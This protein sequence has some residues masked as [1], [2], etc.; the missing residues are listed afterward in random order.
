MKRTAENWLKPCTA[1]LALAMA[2][3]ASHARALDV[4]DPTG[5]NYSSVSDSSHYP[6]GNN[7]IAVNLF[8]LDVTGVALGTIIGSTEFARDGGGDSFVAF[9][10]NQVYTN[11]AS[12]F[13]AQRAGSNPTL[14]KVQTISVWG[15]STTPFTAADPGTSPDSFVTV[16]NSTGAQWTEYM[17]TNTVV[18]QYFLVKFG[19]TTPAGNPGGR[20]FRLGA[21]LGQPPGAFV[22]APTDKTVYAGG[23]AFFSGNVGG[24][25]PPLIYSWTHG[26]TVLANGGRFSGADTG[27]LSISSIIPQDAGSY[28]LTVSNLYGTVSASANLIVVTPPTNSGEAII[29]SQN[30]VA[31]YQLNESAGPTAFD[32]MGSYNGTYGVASILGN[33][34]PQPPSFPGF[35][36]TNTALQTTGFNVDSAVILPPFNLTNPA[37]TN[38]VTILAWIYTDDSG[39]VQQPYT[40]I[41]FGRGAGTAAGLICSSDGTKLGYQWNGNRFGFDSGLVLP[42]NQW[43]LVGMVYTTNFTT[44]YCGTTNGVVLSAVDNFKQAPQ[45]FAGPTYI[46][47]DPDIGESARTFNGMIDDV[48]VYNRALSGG[49]INAIYA[50]ATGANPSVQILNQTTNGFT[51]LGDPISLSVTVSGLNPQFQW[52]KNNASVSGQTNNAYLVTSS[53]QASDAG[54]YYVVASNQV[55]SVTSSVVNVTVTSYGIAPVG[56][57]GLLYTNIAESGEYPDPNN[58]YTSSN[59]F[60]SDLTGV[61]L[62]THLNGAD[63]AIQGA[64]PAFMAF[65]LDQVYA[66]N[67]VFYA[68]RSGSDANADKITAI[69]V[70][71]STTTPFTAADPGTAPD[72]TTSVTDPSGAILNRY[73][74]SSTVS[75]QYFLIKFEQNPVADAPNNNIGGNEFRLGTAV[76]AQAPLTFTAGPGTLTLHWTAG[77][78]Q[79]ATN[80]LGPWNTATGV[81]SDVAIPTTSGGKSFYRLKY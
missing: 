4:I 61:S 47:L 41:V 26:A 12:V 22:T 1:S 35:A 79:T 43:T 5:V 64:G 40:G 32:L 67:S 75:G 59:M 37:T 77:T 16:T 80:L 50:A 62:G 19:Q 66:I 11:V 8:D 53:A 25:T 33:P 23:A 28:T 38:A 29:I 10:L 7:Y 30:P 69:S 44:L 54:A 58:A 39:G 17:L 34:G 70:W 57:S 81:T 13:Y 63:W 18:G 9:Q 52:Y 72:A 55:N 42:T 15:S 56:P 51:V 71:T 76:T 68:Q 3:M 48:A 45:T 49:E 73:L 60:D 21:N 65:Q 31:F 24:G 36:S 2:F 20:E 14:D 74:L 78:L 27:R 46:G 6:D